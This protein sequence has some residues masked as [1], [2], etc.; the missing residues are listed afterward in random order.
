MGM[1]ELH[2][3]KPL[4]FRG[5]AARLGSLLLSRSRVGPSASRYLAGPHPNPSPKGEGL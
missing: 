2:S 3:R 1:G 5:G 4:P